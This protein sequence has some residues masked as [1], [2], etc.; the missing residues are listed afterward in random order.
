MSQSPKSRGLKYLQEVRPEAVHHLLQFF[1][2]S[3][4]HLEPKTRFLI[5]IVTKVISHSERGIRQYVKRALSEGATPDEIIDAVLCSYPCA[6][7]TKV[8]DAIDTILD[9][10]LPDFEESTLAPADADA[11][12]SSADDGEWLEAAG[13]SSVPERG[14]LLVELRSRAIAIFRHEGEILAIDD[15]C[16]HRGGSLAAGLVEEGAVICPLHRWK[17]RL[18]DGQ[19][20]QIPTSQVGTY[21]TRLENDKVLVK[22]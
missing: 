7:L 21:P 5:S 14:G 18:S 22:I 13:L 12:D 8:V 2:E 6:G 17:F 15:E 3:A 1:G 11:V 16:P 19:C 10:G 20:T 4:R 9:M